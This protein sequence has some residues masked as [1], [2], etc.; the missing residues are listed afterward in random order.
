MIS[1]SNTRRREAVVRPSGFE[2]LILDYSPRVHDSEIDSPLFRWDIPL[3][4]EPS[5]NIVNNRVT[6]TLAAQMSYTG[7]DWSPSVGD[8]NEVPFT[9]FHILG[10]SNIQYEYPAIIT[11]KYK[12]IVKNIYAYLNDKD[13]RIDVYRDGIRILTLEP[14]VWGTAYWVTPTRIN[15]LGGETN[16]FKLVKYDEVNDIYIVELKGVIGFDHSFEISI[17]NV[18]G[19]GFHCVLSGDILKIS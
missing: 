16:D 9:P 7:K 4:P 19:A 3:D 15:D 11:V 14:S 12:G 1:R 10:H 8:I 6:K 17:Q 2:R 18:L 13:G 5:V